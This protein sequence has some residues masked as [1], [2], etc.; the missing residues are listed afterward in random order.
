MPCLPLAF[1]QRRWSRRGRGRVFASRGGRGGVLGGGVLRLQRRAFGLLRLRL[2]RRLR[3]LRFS[4]RLRRRLLGARLCLR[5]DAFGLLHLRARLL[6]FRARLFRGAIRG[7]R[8]GGSRRRGGRGKRGRGRRATRSASNSGGGIRGRGGRARRRGFL[9]AL[10]GGTARGGAREGD[11]DHVQGVGLAGLVFSALRLLG[12]TLRLLRL[13]RGS[14]GL[15]LRVARGRGI[16]HERITGR[17]GDP[18]APG[19]RDRVRAG[20]RALGVLSVGGSNFP[21][22]ILELLQGGHAE[23]L[24]HLLAVLNPAL[25][26]ALHLVEHGA[27]AVGA[28]G[29]AVGDHRRRPRALEGVRETTIKSADP[30]RR[31]ETRITQR[32]R[33]PR[34][35]L[36]RASRQSPR[37]AH[38]RRRRGAL[39]FCAPH[40][41]PP[42]H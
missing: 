39:S 12:F 7:A 40:G 33:I 3:R 28:A 31:S 18:V 30:S 27:D 20:E 36:T 2:R 4:S 24:H 8:L 35:S 34:S 6:D 10:V 25:E 38:P 1:L 42:G 22:A 14:P 26:L 32:R 21:G 41:T 17:G 37:D 9:V 11:E 16:H 29:G 15:L 13:G 23:R 5:G 19:R